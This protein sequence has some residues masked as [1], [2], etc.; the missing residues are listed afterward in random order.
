MELYWINRL[1]VL[2]LI[3]GITLAFSAFFTVLPI[4]LKYTED[5][6]EDDELIK[7]KKLKYTS[8]IIFIISLLCMILIPE[9]KELIELIN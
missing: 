2:R 7:L 9:S 8:F 3:I 1:D 6:L 4:V 5:N